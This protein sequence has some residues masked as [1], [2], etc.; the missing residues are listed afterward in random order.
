MDNEN[1]KRACTNCKFFRR[2]YVV[3]ESGKFLATSIGHCAHHNFDKK[4]AAKHT[5]KDEGCFLWQPYEL[6]KL[7]I[8][9][10]I[11]HHLHRI[12][13]EIADILAVLRDAE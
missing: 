9:Y 11:E 10:G 12:E 7:K 13:Q 1:S 5:Q 8:Q 4:V 3:Y 6:Q 2:H